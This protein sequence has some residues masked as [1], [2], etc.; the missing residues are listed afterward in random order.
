MGCEWRQLPC[1]R[2]GEEEEDGT[3]DSQL[4]SRGVQL[5]YRGTNEPEVPGPDHWVRWPEETN[6]GRDTL[7]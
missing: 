7:E 2:W 1:R 6:S 3:K 4:R 5:D